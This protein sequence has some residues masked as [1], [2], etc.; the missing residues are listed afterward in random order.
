MTYT[1]NFPESVEQMLSGYGVDDLKVIGSYLFVTL[2]NSRVSPSGLD[3]PGSATKLPTRKADLIAW[4]RSCLMDEPLLRYVYDL[5]NDLEKAALQETVHESGSYD[6]ERFNAKYGNVPN[7]SIGDQYSRRRADR[8]EPFQFPVLGLFITAQGMMPKDLRQL[9]GKFVHKP[10]EVKVRSIGSLPETV[11]LGKR[12]MEGNVPLVQHNTEQAAAND[13]MAIL[14]LVDMGKIGVS[15]KTGR[16]TPTAVRQIRMVLSNGDFYPEGMEGEKYDIQLGDAGIR[17][18]A[19]T[20]LLQAAGLVRINGG[21]LEL[22]R[23]GKTALNKPAPETLKRIWERWLKYKDF[24]EM[25][26]IEIIKGQKSKKRPLYVAESSRNSIA[27]ALSELEEG[28]WIEIDVFFDFLIAK[29]HKFD[30]LRDGGWALYLGSPQ[31]GS[32]GY[33]HVTWNHINGRFARAFLLEFAATLGVIDVALIPPWGA[34]DDIGDLWGVDDVTCLSRYD[35]L[36]ALRLNSLGAWILDQKEEYTPEFRDQATLK[37]LPNLEIT[38]L[39]ATDN[40][41]DE[42]FLERF[43]DRKSDRIWEIRMAKLLQAI[44]EGIDI[45]SIVAFLE[46]RSLEP[47]PQSVKMF[48]D[49]MGNRVSL[50]QDAGEARLVNCTNK[51]MAQLIANDPRL[52]GICMLAGEQ[53]V[54]VPRGSETRFRRELRNLG[55]VLNIQ[56]SQGIR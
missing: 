29:G 47:F 32:L 1:Y 5:M 43:C 23:N 18:F 10:A 3:I 30:I 42:L 15:P 14:Q 7:T 20:L 27:D 24:H 35:G 4:I 52:K 33:N 53:Y 13:L 56:T 2:K 28:V 46:A 6:P 55:Y 44:E 17:P 36:Y 37:I 16:P 26:R 54:V 38:S 11:Y 48:F 8:H 22:S 39:A 50:I 9:L 51:A 49:D 34:L 41:P 21:K 31:Y 40:K 45:N 25:S 12:G 19:W